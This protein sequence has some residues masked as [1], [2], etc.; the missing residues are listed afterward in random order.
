MNTEKGGHEIYKYNTKVPI[1]KQVIN[2]KINLF[3]FSGHKILIHQYYKYINSFKNNSIGENL[4]PVN[5]IL[6]K[7]KDGC[8]HFFLKNQHYYAT[9]CSQRFAALFPGKTANVRH[10]LGGIFFSS[11]FNHGLTPRGLLL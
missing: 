2:Y 3:I 1:I 5:K 7:A 4:S 9:K 11:E 8:Y 6:Y 10:R